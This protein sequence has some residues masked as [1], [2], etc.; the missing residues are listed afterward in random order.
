MD[1]AVLHAYG[2]DLKPKLEF[3]LDYEDDE[4][5]NDGKK[6]WRYRW[7]DEDRDE[8]LALLLELNRTRAEEAQSAAAPPSG[9]RGRTS[10]KRSPNARPSLFEVQE[11]TE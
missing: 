3:I 9:K 5:V 4:G 11:P 2:W 6:P 1:Y 10:I 8:V 7:V